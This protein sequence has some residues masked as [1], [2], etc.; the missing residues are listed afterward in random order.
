MT[1]KLDSFPSDAVPLRAPQRWFKCIEYVPGL[2]VELPYENESA[3]I[4]AGI[5]HL[6]AGHSGV[7]KIGFY[8]FRSRV[9]VYTAIELSALSAE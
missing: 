1:D 8:G 9:I 7:V 2:K 6:N 5:A 4:A 3:A